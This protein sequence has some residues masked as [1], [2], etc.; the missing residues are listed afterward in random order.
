L[1]HWQE[2]LP[3]DQQSELFKKAHH[4]VEKQIKYIEE[5]CDLLLME[6][7]AVRTTVELPLAMKA[8]KKP[9]EP[10]PKELRTTQTTSQPAKTLA[11]T[12][13]ICPS[14]LRPHG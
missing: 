4:H 11:W 13:S 3:F 10:H 6:D 7:L 2:S 9:S 14:S 8:K 5:R 1:A 12:D